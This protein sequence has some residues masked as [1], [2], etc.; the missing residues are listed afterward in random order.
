MKKSRGTNTQIWEDNINTRGSQSF[1]IFRG[2][3]KILSARRMIWIKFHNENPQ[4]LGA[5]ARNLVTTATWRLVFV[6]SWLILTLKY[7]KVRVW[8][9]L[10]LLKI[11]SCFGYSWKGQWKYCLIKDSTF[12]DKLNAYQ[13]LRRMV[14]GVDNHVLVESVYWQMWG[15]QSS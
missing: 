8:T 2:H 3:L 13:L 5:T 9:V 10:N 14:H 11:G 1:Q 15:V 4:I 6:P 12:L 7:Q